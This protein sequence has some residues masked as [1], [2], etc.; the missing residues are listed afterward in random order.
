MAG[1]KDFRELNVYKASFKSSL[2]IH[3]LSK[4]FPKD[5]IYALTSQIRR[6]S[7]SIC[8][9]IAEGFAKQRQ[10]KVEF[11][12]YLYIAVG[13]ATEVMV[14]LDY[15]KSLSY[16]DDENYQKLSDDYIKIQSM[17]NSF[18]TKIS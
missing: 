16:I 10:S 18:I 13:S 4:Q 1:I 9:N 12:R 6:S 7:K 5:E 8:A 17:L 11:K 15:C 14:W 3:N 2:A